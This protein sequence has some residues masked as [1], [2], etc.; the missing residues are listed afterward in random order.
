MQRDIAAGD[1]I[2]HAEFS[3]NLYGTRWA[4]LGAL[5]SSSS[6]R[7]LE[8]AA[9]AGVSMG[10]EQ[11][12]SPWLGPQVGG[13]FL[14]AVWAGGARDPAPQGVRMQP[15]SGLSGPLPPGPAPLVS[16]WPGC[17]ENSGP[18]KGLV[19][20]EDL[21]DL[22]LIGRQVALSPPTTSNPWGSLRGSLAQ[23]QLPLPTTHRSGVFAGSSHLAC[24]AWKQCLD[25]GRHASVHSL[26]LSHL[27]G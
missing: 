24:K 27:A 8:W 14:W 12:V 7:D 20:N 17:C 25:T 1:F 26:S 4:M 13:F 16:T 9:Q 10:I 23:Q 19:C 15:Q 2:E 18:H 5:P 6:L 22:G 3:G 21:E 11:R